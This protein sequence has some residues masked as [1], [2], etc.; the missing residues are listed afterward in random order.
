MRAWECA[1]HLRANKLCMPRL[2][3]LTKIFSI[4][5]KL[6]RQNNDTQQQR[7]QFIYPMFSYAPYI[8]VTYT[9]IVML[10]WDFRLFSSGFFCHYIRLRSRVHTYARTHTINTIVNVNNAMYSIELSSTTNMVWFHRSIVYLSFTLSLSLALFLSPLLCVRGA[11][12]WCDCVHF[13]SNVIANKFSSL[14]LEQWRN[15]NNSSSSTRTMNNKTHYKNGLENWYGVFYMLFRC[16]H[17][18]PER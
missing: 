5:S 4:H 8:H 7:Q 16:T 10:D 6:Y 14:L 11:Y 12:W 9:F 13:S 17:T 1:H 2:G 3:L 18:R 15:N